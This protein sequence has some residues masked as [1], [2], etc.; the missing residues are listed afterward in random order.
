MKNKSKANSIKVSMNLSTTTVILILSGICCIIIANILLN[1]F[2]DKFLTKYYATKPFLDIINTIGNTL[3]SAGVVSVLVEISTIKGLVSDALDNVLY[4]NIPLDSYSNSVL[5]EINKQIAAKRGL[6]NIEKIDDSIY[7]VEP[8]LIDLLNGL[9]YNYYNMSYEIIPDEK[10]GIFKKEVII[11]YEIINEYDKSNKVSHTIRL[12]D[13]D[14]KMSDEDKKNKFNV[15][16]FIINETDLTN[17]AEKYKELLTIKERHSE[18]QYAIKFERELQ[19]C[20]C[21]KIH[22]EFEYAVPIND[23]SQIFRL[24]YPSKSMLHEIYIN[25]DNGGKWNIH[26]AAFVSFYCKVNNNHGF[27]VE[28][29]HGTHLQISFNDWCIPGAGYVSYLVKK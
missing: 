18:Y 8:N 15:K 26:G 5:K 7:S 14:D 6:V 12:H 19:H 29:K 16:S 28:Q 11:D 4:G 22:L 20:R 24:T 23:T 17:E 13:I 9:Y 3:F 27:H 2:S 25:N 10:N 21:H 1:A